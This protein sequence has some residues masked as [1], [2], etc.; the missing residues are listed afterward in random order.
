M[1][2][3]LARLKELRAP[4][5]EF[6]L[7]AEAKKQSDALVT[8]ETRA[9][10]LINEALAVPAADMDPAIAEFELTAADADAAPATQI[11]TARRI[12]FDAAYGDAEAVILKPTDQFL[13]HMDQRLV[14]EVDAANAT[15]TRALAI[16]V[17]LVLLVVAILGTLGLVLR[18]VYRNVAPLVGA[19]EGIAEGDL[20]QQFSAGSRDEIGALAGAMQ[21]M[22]AYLN[23][24]AGHAD[25]IAAGD[26]T[27][28][29]RPRSE[30]DVL[31][32]AFAAM[33]SNLRGL[34]GKMS[35]TGELALGGLAADGDDVRRRPARRPGRSRPRS[36]TSRAGRRAPVAHRRVRAGRGRGGRAGRHRD[37]A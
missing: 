26:L 2:K 13:T 4:Q 12:M 35:V 33:A 9:M 7:L 18:R 11:K 3:V 10:R 17:G 29:V 27:V 19:A 16:L 1:E 32:T 5:E 8:T 28:D 37:R 20:E 14:A 34:V 15:A 6:A 25:R 31:G 36:A 21:G 22:L 24:M 30:R 23:E